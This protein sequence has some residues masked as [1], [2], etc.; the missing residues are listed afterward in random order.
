MKDLLNLP[1][2]SSKPRTTGRTQVLDKGESLRHLEDQLEL[3]GEYV[4]L[5]RLGWGTSLVTSKLEDKIALYK[6]FDIEVC[7]GGTLFELAFLKERVAEYASWLKHLGVTSVE[8]SDGTLEIEQKRKSELIES[9]AKDGFRVYSEVGSKDAE[10]IVSPIRWVKQIQAELEAGATYVILEGRE[11][12]TAGM[13]RTSGEIR[14]GLVDEIVESG[15]P[16]ERLV[17]EAPKKSQQVW[18]LKQIGG[19]ANLA[20]IAL[21]EVIPVETL[22]LG[23]RSDTLRHFHQGGNR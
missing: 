22:R 3:V 15:V 5:A 19:N 12:G 14:M 1:S 2:R 16:V 11:S 18:L 17:F 7:F 9:F 6:R 23:L 8:I 21:S 10:V 20:N 4:D 13:Y